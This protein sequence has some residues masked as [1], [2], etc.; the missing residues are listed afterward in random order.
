MTP[1]SL[2]LFLDHLPGRL[3]TLGRA[4]QLDLSVV[5]LQAGEAWLVKEKEKKVKKSEGEVASPAT[6]C[7]GWFDRLL[8]IMPVIIG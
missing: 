5:G 1:I 7:I 3:D 8:K 6:L 2:H 4:A